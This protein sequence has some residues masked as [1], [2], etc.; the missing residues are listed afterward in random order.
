MHSWQTN[1]SSVRMCHTLLVLLP[2]DSSPA[3]NVNGIYWNSSCKW[4]LNICI[5]QLCLSM[6]WMAGSHNSNQLPQN[7]IYSIHHCFNER[8]KISN[9]VISTM[10]RLV[11]FLILFRNQKYIEHQLFRNGLD[12]SAVMSKPKC[13]FKWCGVQYTSNHTSAIQQH[14]QFTKCKWCALCH[15]VFSFPMI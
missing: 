3:H 8:F 13:H 10:N 6:C 5:E 11:N 1:E 9:I 7:R 4:S 15:V 12:V 2:H 14:K